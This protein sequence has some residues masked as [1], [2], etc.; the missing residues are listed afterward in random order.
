MWMTFKVS[1]SSQRNH[2][3]R[4]TT[5][6]N[7]RLIAQS[8]ASFSHISKTASLFFLAQGTPITVSL[9]WHRAVY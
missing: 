8:S 7:N 9:I 6:M 2:V 4:S 5:K 1:R 3:G